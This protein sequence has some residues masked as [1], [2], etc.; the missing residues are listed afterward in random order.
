MTRGFPQ[1]GEQ[2]GDQAA[3]H[4]NEHTTPNH[5]PAHP[6]DRRGRAGR[7]LAD[8]GRWHEAAIA[9]QCCGMRTTLSGRPIAPS[10]DG[11]EPGRATTCLVGDA[12]HAA[13]VRPLLRAGRIQ[14]P[15]ARSRSGRSPAQQLDRFDRLGIAHGVGEIGRQGSGAGISCPWPGRPDCERF[16]PLAV[17]LGT[18]RTVGAVAVLWCKAHAKDDAIPVSDDG[19]TWCE[20]AKV[21]PR[22][23]SGPHAQTWLGDSDVIRFAPA[24][25]RHVP[26]CCT[27]QAV[28]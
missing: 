13:S 24:R 21:E 25:T 8:H 1:H 27:K 22:V 28:A 11:E 12:G 5:R 19:K 23:S 14:P 9:R 2:P 3:A 15:P 20:A 6:R 10:H 7:R 17:D 4:W 16:G 26:L 18:Q